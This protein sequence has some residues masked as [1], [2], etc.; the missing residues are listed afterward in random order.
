MDKK[1]ERIG[2]F[3]VDHNK[4][5]WGVYVFLLVEVGGDFFTFFDVRM[6]R[7][8]LESVLDIAIMH[9]M[10]HLGATFLRNHDQWA[11]KTDLLWSNGLPYRFLSA[12]Q[13]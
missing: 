8:N 12:S 6:K 7:P 13:G 10:E 3:S 1:M 5:K 9:A 4:L 2:S 11:D